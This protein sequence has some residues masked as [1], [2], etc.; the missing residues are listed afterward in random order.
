MSQRKLKKISLKPTQEQLEKMQR[1]S[2][3]KYMRENTMVSPSEREVF[4]LLLDMAARQSEIYDLLKS[5]LR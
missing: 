5:R 3:I 2:R 4:R 1:E